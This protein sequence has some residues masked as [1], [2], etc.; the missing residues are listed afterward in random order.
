[1]T[2]KSILF[3]SFQPGFHRRLESFIVWIPDTTKKIFQI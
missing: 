2:S 3:L 1:M